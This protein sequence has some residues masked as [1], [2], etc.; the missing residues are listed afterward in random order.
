LIKP[1]SQMRGHPVRGQYR[2][3]FFTTLAHMQTPR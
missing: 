3:R 2:A 1:A